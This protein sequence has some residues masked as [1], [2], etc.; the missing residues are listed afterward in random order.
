MGS[1][2]QAAWGLKE[3]IFVLTIKE[4]VFTLKCML[5]ASF[6]EAQVEWEGTEIALEMPLIYQLLRNVTKLEW[7]ESRCMSVV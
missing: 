3:S 1:Q 6:L 4:D 7:W 2:C 5:F